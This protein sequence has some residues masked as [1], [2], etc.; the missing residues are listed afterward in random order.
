MKGWYRDNYRHS[1]AARGVVMR[2]SYA[3]KGGANLDWFMTSHEVPSQEYKLAEAE[4][5]FEEDNW[6]Y[7]K[8][9]FDDKRKAMADRPSI[10]AQPVGPSNNIMLDIMEDSL[11]YMMRPNDMNITDNPLSAS[12]KESFGEWIIKPKTNEILKGGMADN[13]PDEEFDHDQLSKGITVEME[14]TNDPDIAKEV[15][16]DHIVETG[17][18]NGKIRSRYYDE[19]EKMEQ[20]I[21]APKVSI[22]A[23]KPEFSEA[24]I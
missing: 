17:K 24:S 21:E 15:A 2:R 4:P 14:H 5:W 23:Y 18:K 9:V 20:K 12:I 8:D 16:K 13:I 22:Q 10:N 19:L 1:L 7:P 6:R 11:D 3:M